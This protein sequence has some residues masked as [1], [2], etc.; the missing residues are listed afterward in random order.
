MFRAYHPEGDRLVAIKVFQLDLLP[1]QVHA[2]AAELQQLVDRRLAHPGIV[3]PIA[4]GVEGSSVYLAQEFC[5]GDSLDVAMRQGERWTGKAGRQLIQ[6]V[7]S[8]I[9]VAAAH[10][11]HHGAL[12]P[13]D[14]LLTGDTVQVTG[15][16]VT[17]A[18]ERVGLRVLGRHPYGAPERTAGQAWG[19]PADVFALAVLAYE[20]LANRRVSGIGDQSVEQLA[21]A[22]DADPRLLRR[23]FATALAAEPATRYRTARAFTAA[24][25][26]ALSAEAVQSP[27]RPEEPRL[28]LD[29]PADVAG[30][31]AAA[32]MDGDGDG[33]GERT[34]PDTTAEAEIADVEPA[35]LAVAV[36][37]ARTVTGPVPV[38]GPRPPADND[39]HEESLAD[40]DAGLARDPAEDEP[41]PE[42]P[43]E[44]ELE[45]NAAGVAASP[46]PSERGIGVPLSLTAA[47]A[48]DALDLEALDEPVAEPVERAESAEPVSRESGEEVVAAPP[49]APAVAAERP[50]AASASAP[51]AGQALPPAADAPAARPARPPSLLDSPPVL[52]L[53]GA[54]QRT[55]NW[56]IFVALTVGLLVGFAVGVSVASFFY[57][58]GASVVAGSRAVAAAPASVPASAPAQP[59]ASAAVARPAAPKA[60]PAAPT[61]GRLLM[62]STP[63]GARVILQ[64]RERGVTPLSL[65]G[66]PFG[67][68]RVQ[69]ARD[70][71][72]TEEQQVVLSA[73]RADR[74]VAVRLRVASPVVGP[75]I[76]VVDTR[77]A[78]AA[79]L[80]DGKRV[81]A[82]PLVL[83]GVMSGSHRVRL[84]LP[85]YRPWETTVAIK[86]GTR[87]RV[88]ASLEQG[89]NR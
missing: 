38:P 85:G 52:E 13:R 76:L 6:A 89:S 36:P 28:P 86:A 37:R 21:V 57:T 3:A 82:T 12:H 56:P 88:T 53:A 40:F 26:A 50:V 44:N 51:A 62:R 31:S 80:V 75:G 49:V 9:D 33:D 34:A 72:R 54:G 19:T 35:P 60:V 39:E 63:S 66:L 61:G 25:D 11:A 30:A 14:I 4:A 8:A 45:L 1:E 83:P 42:P 15:F 41:E 47:T 79:V 16:G 64:G 65:S 68:Y 5:G 29:G 69:F 7:A 87:S 74:A 10:G 67:T 2:L 22:Q 20:L 58:P 24:L 17:E 71:Y 48:A 81:G 27:G 59:P 73:S 77:P 43:V 78:G 23:V 70:G 46:A 55:G 84:E 18:L 32:S